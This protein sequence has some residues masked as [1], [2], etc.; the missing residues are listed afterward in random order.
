M[1][2][3]IIPLKCYLEAPKLLPLPPKTELSEGSSFRLFCYSSAGTK[4]LFYQ[5]S[6]NGQNLV[7][8]P[9]SSFKIETFKDNSQFGIEKVDRNDSGNYSCIARNAF[10]TDIQSAL[11]IVKG[12][13]IF[14][15]FTIFFSLIK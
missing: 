2:Y 5:W 7:N 15:Y 1:N 14:I 10:G 13:K 4:P 3:I 6:K 12:L 9:H 11:L 8:N